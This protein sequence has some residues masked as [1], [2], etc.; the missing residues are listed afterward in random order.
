M[1]AWLK[2]VLL[3]I[4]PLLG[5][6]RRISWRVWLGAACLGL[7]ILWFH[8]HDARIRQSASLA[9]TQREADAEISNLKKQAAA[10]IQAANVAN[11]QAL[12]KLEARRQEMERQNQELA[13]Q[14]ASLRKQ[15]QAQTARVAT[16]PTSE[17]VTRVATQLGL[18][19]QD[20]APAGGKSATVAT[21]NSRSELTV[22]SFPK[23]KPTVG[24][25][26][27]VATTEP[28][29]L[30]LSASGARKVETALVELDACHR[31]SAVEQQ[32]IA[33][34]QER[35]ATDAETI[36]RQADSIG[37]LNQVLAAKDQIL[38]RQQAECKA[39]LG[40]ARGTFWGRLARAS[41]HVLIGVAVGV[42]IGVVAR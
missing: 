31:E 27:T 30:P 8:R 9:Q 38:A 23:E 24:S 32:Q 10:N 15:Q 4:N 25:A 3:R 37:K 40:A 21:V 34:C 13:A 41:K 33:N 19:A 11:A 12:E 39:E 18:E 28:S 6:A 1:S 36:K 14:L 5:F 35:A 29:V 42:V 22:G 26:S 2:S 17:V 7:V 20:L 16:L